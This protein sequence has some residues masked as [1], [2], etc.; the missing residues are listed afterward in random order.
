VANFWI[1]VNDEDVIKSVCHKKSE[2]ANKTL[3]NNYLKINNILIN[4]A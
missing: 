4:S 2:V 3:I 1:I